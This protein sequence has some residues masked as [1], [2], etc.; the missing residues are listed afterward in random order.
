[1]LIGT[2]KDFVT[3]LEIENQKLQDA[4]GYLNEEGVALLRAYR[5]IRKLTTFAESCQEL[6]ELEVGKDFEPDEKKAA[7]LAMKSIERIA[8]W[9]DKNDKQENAIGRARPADE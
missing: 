8:A 6:L 4:E 1:M 5:K 7:I 2:Y 9:E 3:V